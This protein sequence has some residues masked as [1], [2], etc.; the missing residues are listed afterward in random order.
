MTFARYFKISSYAL[1]ASGF[2]AI[3]A[4]GTIDLPAVLLFSIVLVSSWWIDTERLRGRTPAWVLNTVALGYFPLYVADYLFVSHSFVTSTVH[5]IFYMAALK[6]VTRASDRDYVYL[7]LISFAELL[8]A[9]TLTIDITFAVSLAAFLVSAVNTLILFEMRRSNARARTEG[10]IQPVV[11]AERVRGTGYEL[12]SRFPAAPMGW[13]SLGLTVLILALAVPIFVLMPRVALGV[14]NR[15]VGRGQLLSG[16]SEKVELGE[17]GTIKESETVVMRVKL[18]RSAQELPVLRLRGVSMERYDGR[19][20]SR[21]ADIGR[22]SQPAR[23]EYYKLEEEIQERALLVEQTFFL[24]GLSTRAVFA[25]AKALAVSRSFEPLLRAESGDLSMLRPLFGKLRYSVISD[26][27]PVDTAALWESSAGVP[28][29]VRRRYLQVPP[30][31]GRIA[32]LARQITSGQSHPYRKALALESHLKRH[33]GYSLELKG[34][35]TTADPLAGFLFDVRKGHCEYFASALAIMLRQIGIPARLVNGFR[36]GEY[37]PLGDSWIVRQYDAHSWVEAYF[38]PYGWIELDPTPPD[39]SRSRA[40]LLKAIADLM[41]AIDLWWAEEVVNYTLWK[42]MHV[43]SNARGRIADFQRR[44]RSYYAAFLS[45]ARER[46]DPSLLRRFAPAGAAA[47]LVLAAVLAGFGRLRRRWGFRLGP[48]LRRVFGVK[49]S[50]QSAAG[51]YAEALRLLETRGFI[52][53]AD[54]TPVE[55]ALSLGT[56]PT[57]GPL[58]ELTRIYNRIRFG[59]ADRDEDWSEAEYLMVFL[60]DALRAGRLKEDLSP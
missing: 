38:A 1:I 2:V 34:S 56:H 41:D 50:R 12:F 20:W 19:S 52:R 37:N 16:F 26:V 43:L 47:G 18:N 7:Y 6:L 51:F 59:P 44:I 60:R 8:A 57:A 29:D 9:S 25:A 4:T 32:V 3:A 55:F 48:L 53:S 17:I 45:D 36:M 5:L 14:Y 58:L 40:P 13:M 24:E 27:T 10:E 28:D 35:P 15:P 39:P 22:S 46:L 11:V 54:Q 21:A 33:Y 42:Q 23:G 30:L 49:P 31:D